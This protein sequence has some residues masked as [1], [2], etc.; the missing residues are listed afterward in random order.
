MKNDF[1]R[2]LRLDLLMEKVLERR[3]NKQI[4][5]KASRFARG[6]FV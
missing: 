2:Y 5:K 3:S 4:N 6:F 1:D